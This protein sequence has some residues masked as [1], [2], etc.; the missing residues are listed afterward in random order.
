MMTKWVSFVWT[1]IIANDTE[2][3][4]KFQL[5]VRFMYKEALFEKTF[6]IFFLQV[7]LFIGKKEWRES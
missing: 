6:L 7:W 2:L 1:L 5:K 4:Q 3:S